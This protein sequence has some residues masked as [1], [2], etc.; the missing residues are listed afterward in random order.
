MGD[1]K[2]WFDKYG[3]PHNIPN[4]SPTSTENPALFYGTYIVLRYATNQ[5]TT[6]DCLRFINYVSKLHGFKLKGFSNKIKRLFGLDWMA[7]PDS[8]RYDFS[9]DNWI[10]VSLALR[11]IIEWTYGYRHELGGSAHERA[12]KQM[13]HVRL[14]HP[15]LLHPVA[16]FTV[17]RA[18]YDIH[19]FDFII[20]LGNK[21]SCK[22]THKV[23]GELK[24]AKTDGK[25]MA[26][27]TAT[28]F[29]Y[30]RGLEYNSLTLTT[31][32]IA[33]LPRNNKYVPQVKL[34]SEL[35]TIWTWGSWENI[36]LDYYNMSPEHPNV[37]LAHNLDKMI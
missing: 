26:L 5:L 22:E 27:M 33:P 24:I 12:L 30:S 31:T 15:Q 25:I 9:K 37:K 23:R 36:F 10:G 29:D 32:R 8:D 17:F 34:E 1:Q 13:K 28:A 11:C 14:L 35:D 20:K 19:V 4:P 21:I 2:F 6:S 7:T 18:K 16:W 3:A